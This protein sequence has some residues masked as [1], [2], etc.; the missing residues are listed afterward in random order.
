MQFS[1]RLLLWAVLILVPTMTLAAERRCALIDLDR[2]ALGGLME[3]DLLTLPDTQWVERTEIQ[4][5][6]NEQ[7]LQSILGAQSGDDRRSIGTVLKADVLIILRTVEEEQK[8]YA[9][10]VVAETNQGIRL[11]SQRMLLGKDPSSDAE[12]LVKLAS[13]GIAKSQE[14][15]QHIFAVPPFVSHDLTYEYDYLKSAYAKLVER[16]LLDAPGVVVVELDEAKTI[17]TEYNLAADGANVQRRLPTYVLGEYRNEGRGDERRVRLSLKAQQGTKVINETDETIEPEAASG[18]LLKFSQELASASGLAAVTIAPQQEVKL[19]NERADLFVRLANWDEAQALVEASLLLVPNQPKM[20]SQAITIVENRLKEYPLQSIEHIENGVRLKH[21]ALQHIQ[22]L[23]NQSRYN[24]AAQHVRVFEKSSINDLR[25]FVKQDPDVEKFIQSSRDYEQLRMTLANRMIHGLAE[26]K[27]WWPSAWVLHMVVRDWKPQQRYAAIKNILLKY[28]HLTSDEKFTRWYILANQQPDFVRGLEGR[29]FLQ[30]LIASPQVL[31][32]VRQAAESIL[33]EIGAKPPA[34]VAYRSNADS[35]GN[36]NLTFRRIEIADLKTIYSCESLGGGWDLVN[37][38]KAYYLYSKDKGL[39]KIV[40]RPRNA[41]GRFYYDGKYVW[42][43]VRNDEGGLQLAVVDPETRQRYDFS[44][45]DGLPLLSPQEVPDASAGDFGILV[46]PVSVG[47]VIVV[48]YVGRTWFADVTFSPAGDHQVNIFHE[49]KETLPED[50]SKVRPDDLNLRFSPH[51]IAPLAR[52]EN[53]KVVERGFLLNRFASSPVLSS[54][55]LLINPDDL[56]IRVLDQSW[57]ELAGGWVIDG[58]LFREK[59]IAPRSKGAGLYRRGLGDQQKTLVLSEYDD[60]SFCYD[61]GTKIL[62]VAGQEWRQADLSTGKMTSLGPVPWVYRSRWS[63]S[64]SGP[65]T[66]TEDGTYSLTRLYYANSFGLI[67]ICSPQA[68]GETL[69]LQVLFDGSGES[70][71]S[72]AGI[73]EEKEK[74]PDSQPDFRPLQ[75]TGR[76]NLWEPSERIADVEYSPTGEFVVTVSEQAD[77][78]VRVWNPDSGAIIASL[79]DQPQG[80]NCVTF[81]PG[82]EYFAT[83]GNDG[84]VILWDAKSLRPLRQWTDLK[85]VV[86]DLAFSS[87]AKRLAASDKDGAACVWELESGKKMFD[88]FGR[89]SSRG[90]GKLA[91]TPDDTL[92]LAIRGHGVGVYDAKRGSDLGRMET[93]GWVAGFLPDGSLL[94]VGNEADNDLVRRQPDGT[95]QVVWPHFP[96]GPIAISNNSRFVATFFPHAVQDGKRNFFFA[97]VEVWDAGTKTL[98]FAEEGLSDPK[99]AFSPDSTK[100]IVRDSKGVA[101]QVGLE[102]GAVTKAKTPAPGDGKLLTP[103]RTWTDKSGQFQIDAALVKLDANSAV[104]KTAEGKQLTIPLSALSEADRRFL[105]DFAERN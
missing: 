25:I 19:L 61:E 24:M 1:Y 45:Q 94:G 4:K 74:Q 13:D 44:Q 23:V 2:S 104:L 77:R 92:L 93:F 56:T 51:Q 88:F 37:A 73:S 102:E 99:I 34:T 83:G 70:F 40:D 98:V 26:G 29:E 55:P 105:K 78:S 30:D 5:L 42:V 14:P 54:H 3:A 8:K 103:M 48:G 22:V 31:P 95:A 16:T 38:D 64:G 52:K 33:K 96:G 89:S 85:G 47:R 65:V 79:L 80:M 15:I 87:D 91:F 57:S 90:F 60:G 46:A 100:L 50:P 28:Q 63:L 43:T 66:R 69:C 27:A 97:R 82:G 9:Q 67:A 35:E 36:E 76:E 101:K 17:T 72:A 75:I 68:R 84:R 39:Q 21:H 53:G 32:H 86:T 71:K 7:R 11:V 41:G 81:S 18:T 6:L 59:M 20:H 58:E 49:A 62:H 10:L 12:M